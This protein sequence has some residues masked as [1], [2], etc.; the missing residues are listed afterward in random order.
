M[1]TFR[2]IEIKKKDF[3]DK[4]SYRKYARVF[5][6]RHFQNK[7]PLKNVFLT[8]MNDCLSRIETIKYPFNRSLHLPK[9]KERNPEVLTNLPLTKDKIY[10]LYLHLTK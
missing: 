3:F 6:T 4:I 5:F 8:C 9:K 1:F 2:F 10:Q 7:I